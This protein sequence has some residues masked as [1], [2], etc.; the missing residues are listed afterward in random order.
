MAFT[1]KGV[2]VDT[3]ATWM[4]GGTS[5]CWVFKAEDV[6]TDQQELAT[7][8]TNAF[9]GRDPF[10]IDGVGGG[11]SVTSKAL[12]M[13]PGTHGCDMD[14]LFAQVAIGQD[15]VEFDSNCGNCA[16]AAALWVAEESGNPADRVPVRLFN[17]N[18]NSI[19]EAVV[20]HT[21]GQEVLDATVPGVEGFGVAVELAFVNPEGGNTGTLWPTGHALDILQLPDGQVQASM[22]DAGA[23]VVLVDASGVALPAAATI[24]EV[25]SK[26]PQLRAIRRAAALSMGLSKPDEPILDSVPKVGVVDKPVD[27][28][29]TA[30]HHISAADYDVSVRMLS[31]MATHPAIGLTSAVALTLQC[32]ERDSILG[33]LTTADPYQ[34]LTLGTPGGLVQTRLEKDGDTTKVFLQRAARRIADTTLHVPDHSKKVT[35]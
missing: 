11:T 18:T 17:I 3:T 24:T 31:M 19:V 22:T 10:E 13:S 20:H 30:G 16:T 5:K 7:F 21:N 23:P 25:D 34:G 8:L 29:T 15:S 14:Y 9:G 35:R 4:R 27:Y 28:V 1:A 26:V 12:I 2:R 6:P 32:L 33:R